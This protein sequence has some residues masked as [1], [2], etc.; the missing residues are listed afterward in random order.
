RLGRLRSS[1]LSC[2]GRLG[3]GR[4]CRVGLLLRG[5]L[6]TKILESAQ[7]GEGR[8]TARR[9][10]ILTDLASLAIALSAPL[11]CLCL[12]AFTLLSTLLG[13]LAED[14]LLLVRVEAD[15]LQLQFFPFAIHGVE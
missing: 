11:A 6:G 2:C 10:L 13:D 9:F 8:R 7:F 3:R 4:G 5:H 12:A 1:F 15:D 14:D